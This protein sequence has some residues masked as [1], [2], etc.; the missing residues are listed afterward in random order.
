MF[1][2]V[3]RRLFCRCAVVLRRAAPGVLCALLV[4]LSLSASAMQVFVRM[5]M[6][7]VL[8]LDVLPVQRMINVATIIETLRGIPSPHQRMQFGGTVV[9]GNGDAAETMTLEEHGIQNED[10]I[11]LLYKVDGGGT[12]Y[13]NGETTATVQDGTSW[14]YAMGSLDDALT[15]ARNQNRVSAGYVKQIWVARGT[16]H[17]AR[18]AAAFDSQNAPTTPSDRAFVLVDNVGLYGGFAGT[19]TTITQRLKGPVYATTLSGDTPAHRDQTP[20]H[21]VISAADDGAHLLD[22]LVITGG[23]ANNYGVEH[24]IMVND[25]AIDSDGGGGIAAMGSRLTL[26]NV[27]LISNSASYGGGLFADSGTVTGSNMTMIRNVSRIGGGMN[28]RQTQAVLTNCLLAS[29]MALTGTGIYCSQSPAILTNLSVTDNLNLNA[30]IAPPPAIGLEDGVCRVRNSL[31]L[32][33]GA[34]DVVGPVTYT[35]SYADGVLHRP[36][37]DATVSLDST[38]VFVNPSPPADALAADYRLKSP[39]LAIDAGDSSLFAPGMTPD[40]SSIKTDIAGSPRTVFDAVDLGAYEYNPQS[41][42]TKWA[43]Y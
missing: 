14:G 34:H 4:S 6:G 19:E 1:R 20:Y 29:N 21:V 8:T 27:S 31:L 11:D 25:Q 18:E 35:N 28:F 33:N 13:V 16:Y 3:L 36:A 7:T 40:L 10:T 5:P 12:L 37:G 41:F 17:P 43:E 23:N 22:S 30:G 26:R 9:F 2:P 42:V 32:H 39:G 38:S 15:V 24:K